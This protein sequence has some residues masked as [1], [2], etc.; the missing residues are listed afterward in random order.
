MRLGAHTL[1]LAAQQDV[2]EVPGSE[3]LVTLPPEPHHRREQLLGGNGAIPR[4]GRRQAGVAV[5]AGHRGLAEVAQQL[6][7]AALDGLAERQ[8]GVEVRRELAAVRQIALALVDH[9]ALLHHVLQS[10]G[11]PGRRRQ[12]VAA[13]PAGLL[14]V[15]LDALRQIKVGDEAHVG[16]VDPHAEGDRGDHHDPVFSQEARLIA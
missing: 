1:G 8:H 7:T 13:G 6:H 2:D 3:A 11:E 16:F 5:A 12:A 14:V 4:L 15:A 9:A 10:I